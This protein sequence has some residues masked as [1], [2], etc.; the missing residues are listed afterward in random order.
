MPCAALDFNIL[1]TLF[2]F[3]NTLVLH[4]KSL[5]KSTFL[6]PHPDALSFSPAHCCWA[7][8][9]HGP[10]LRLVPSTEHSL[11][12]G[13]SRESGEHLEKGLPVGSA[14]PDTSP[15][16]GKRGSQLSNLPKSPWV[17][18]VLTFSCYSKPTFLWVWRKFC[19][20][21]PNIRNLLY[22]RY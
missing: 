14:S 3:L 8:A 10:V 13:Q 12:N 19:H 15:G 7:L 9:N 21:F 6:S 5:C 11:R 16:S 17:A 2:H 4:Q 20:L 22:V 1:S 18:Q